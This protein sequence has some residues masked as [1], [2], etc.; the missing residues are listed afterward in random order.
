MFSVPRRRLGVLAT[1]L[2]A[3]A[4]A[5]GCAGSAAKSAT[6]PDGNATVTIESGN[7]A[8]IDYILHFAQAKGFFAQNHIIAKPVDFTAGTAAT[9]A[10]QS[11]SVDVV[12]IDPNNTGPLMA[13][14]LQ[15]QL[16]SGGETN[17]WSLLVPARDAG[18]PVQDV[19]H[20]AK[21]IGVPSVGG[22]GSKFLS[23][24]ENAYGIPAGQIQEVTDLNGAGFI[25]GHEDALMSFPTYSCV[26]QSQGAATAFSYLEPVENPGSY[27][28]AL[29]TLIG[30][31]DTGFWVTKSWADANPQVVTN[32]QKALS[33]AISYLNA[34]ANLAAVTT[35]L[36]TS[37]ENVA[38]L[39]DRQFADCIAETAPTFQARFGAQDAQ[40][41]SD[42]VQ[43]GGFVPGGLPPADQWLR[44]GIPAA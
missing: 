29:R 39:S 32:L 4:L 21:T 23:Y 5:A 14:G 12:E 1:L 35:D 41:W 38:Q 10:L 33:Q 43:R 20:T 30:L 25:S 15:L 7:G 9:A 16:I 42:L 2:A 19:L 6:G 24:L 22:A 8:V 34:P 36:R 13:K 27:P 11:G 44:A 17:Y 40:V 31:P 18:K 3:A 28:A 26:A 37:T